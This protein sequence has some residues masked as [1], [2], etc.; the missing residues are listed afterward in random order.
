MH[1]LLVKNVSPSWLEAAIAGQISLAPPQIILSDH[2]QGTSWFAFDN[3]RLT[4]AKVAEMFPKAIFIH[5]FSPTFGQAIIPLTQ[6]QI[7]DQL[8]EAG[9]VVFD[10]PISEA[11]RQV[12]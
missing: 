6:E 5:D 11:A 2:G 12:I 7:V 1:L 8:A 10:M 9:H 4:P 3:Q